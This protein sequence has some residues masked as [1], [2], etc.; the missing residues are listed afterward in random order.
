MLIK[1]LINFYFLKK[2]KKIKL[3][4]K[5]LQTQQNKM[6]ILKKYKKRNSSTKIKLRHSRN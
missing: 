6:N 4:Y 3:F 5:I 2:F 1:N